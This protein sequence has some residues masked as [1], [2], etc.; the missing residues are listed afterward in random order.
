MKKKMAIICSTDYIT[1]PM[2]GMMSFVLDILPHMKDDFDIT[3]WGVSTLGR[4]PKSININGEKYPFRVFSSVKMSKKIIPNFLR[5]AYCI[6]SNRKKIIEEK[7]DILYIHG[8]PLSFPFLVDNQVKV[9]NHI[10]G[11]SNP[12]ASPEKKLSNNYLFINLYEYYRRWVIKKSDLI[13]L[14]ADKDG[15]KAFLENYLEFSDKIKCMPNFADK[16][17]FFPLEINKA[18]RLLRIN[19]NEIILVNTG[20][21]SSGKDPILLLNS[22]IYLIQ[23]LNIKAHL[24][25]IGE[26]D[27]KE[28][29]IKIIKSKKIESSVTV[30]GKLERKDINLWLNAADLYV[31]TSIAEGYP[32]ALAEAATCRLPIVTMDILG[33]H[34]L[35]I[36]DHSGCLVKKREPKE[37]AEK[38]LLALQNKKIFSENIQ[39]I[40][41][42][43]TP[44]IVTS[45]MKKMLST[46]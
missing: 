13:L 8:I 29:I 12:F 18:R 31:S 20:R 9:V 2:G 32:I 33:V 15:H 28:T 17:I 27:L 23:S 21:I 36:D 1:Y 40:S 45:R 24:V 25:I 30:T 14:A 3:L 35:V 16:N 5:V 43:F 22:F 10:H 38:I 34:D 19:L 7:Y 11:H 39:I 26:G 4:Y 41:K 44:E 46:L 37:V 42:N 6:W